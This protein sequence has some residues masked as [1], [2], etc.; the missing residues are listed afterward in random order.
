MEGMSAPVWR[1]STYS[2]GA[3]GSCV[4]VAATYDVLVRDT[5]D[6]QGPALSFTPGAWR[7]FTEGLKRLQ[8]K[9]RTPDGKGE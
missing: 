7:R 3:S 4:E 8:G 9:R 5:T 2:G 6:R 1:K